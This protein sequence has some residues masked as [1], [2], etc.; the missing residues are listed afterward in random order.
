MPPT[1]I[2]NPSTEPG[3][4]ADPVIGR[5]VD[6]ERL[7]AIYGE[8]PTE[9]VASEGLR[10]VQESLTNAVIGTGIDRIEA[11][12]NGD[13]G[14]VYRGFLKSRYSSEPP[15]GRSQARLAILEDGVA[16]SVSRAG[17]FDFRP[18]LARMLWTPAHRAA[19]LVAPERL[20]A[21]FLDD[22]LGYLLNAPEVFVVAGEAEQ[23]QAYLLGLAHAV[24]E[25]IRSAPN[26]NVTATVASNFAI[27]ANLIPAYLSCGNVRELAEKR[28]AI[29][30]FVFGRCGPGLGFTPPRRPKERDR[31]KVGYLN[32]HFGALTETHVAL[33]TLQLDRSRFEICLFAVLSSPGPVEDRCRSFADSYTLLP[34]MLDEQ[35]RAIRAARLDVL[36]VGTNITAVTNQVSLIAL[37]RIAPIQLATYCSPMS[38]GMRNI[39]GYLSGTLAGSAALQDQ[40][41]E[42]LLLCG[43][44][45]GCLDYAVE[46]KGASARFEPRRMRQA[47][48]G[49]V[50][51]NAASCFKILPEMQDTWARILKAVPKSRLLLL[52]FN[53][54]WS[55]SF[56]VRQFERTLTEACARHGMGKNSFLLANALPS[57]ADVKALEKVGDVYLDTFPF[58]GSISVIDPLELGIPVVV[59]EG[60]THRSRASSALL[61]ELGLSE[62]IVQ[63]EASYIGLAVALA[64]DAAYRGRVGRQILDAMANKPQ[65]VNPA[66]YARRL[67]ELIESLVPAR[68]SPKPPGVRPAEA[69]AAAA[70]A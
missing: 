12:F 61:R 26:D 18:L 54:N 40:F 11:L 32:S 34:R 27:R 53:P 57:R 6:I 37:H 13:F 7:F 10:S 64:T 48:D 70:A 29:M 20:P 66:A 31:I 39:D 67:G 59:W 21:W 36:I 58:S 30:A 45:P 50:F 2:R 16:Q 17:A 9:Y 62:L 56:P 5:V 52:P 22:Y 38:T 69:G 68:G 25:R 65:F 33:P 63:D 23:Y 24:C 51:V 4:P 15:S 43:G 42:K 19:G 8:R 14:R 28:A 1:L 35:V 60:K 47:E 41:S 3:L 46:G 55:T 44:P 49:V